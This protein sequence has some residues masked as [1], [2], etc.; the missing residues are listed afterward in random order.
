MTVDFDQCKTGQPWQK[1]TTLLCSPS[2][3]EHVAEHFEPLQCD[4]YDCRNR[5][6]LGRKADG[7][8][9]SKGAEAYTSEMNRLLAECFGECDKTVVT[10]EPSVPASERAAFA[11]MQREMDTHVNGDAFRADPVT[12]TEHLAALLPVPAISRRDA[13]LDALR[14][15]ARQA[16][17][18]CSFTTIDSGCSCDVEDDTGIMGFIGE[19]R[20][21]STTLTTGTNQPTKVQFEGTH[22]HYLLDANLNVV[23][24]VRHNV[25]CTAGTKFQRCLW[26]PR[27]AAA[28]RGVLTII[29]NREP[30]L[31]WPD[32][33][34][35]PYEDT[36]RGYYLRRYF[37]KES[38]ERAVLP[39]SSS[40]R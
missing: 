38:A 12:M 28:N 26:A 27:A 34:R 39:S 25:L 1:S 23:E 40:R 15:E 16:G 32:G 11:R 19:R 10:P 35:I 21:S 17:L 7:S 5:N 22:R 14:T 31:Q 9:T 13:K 6:L 2:I 20:P 3:Y 4:H 36:E 8:F 18:E 33:T 24:E 37:T 29:G 30:Y